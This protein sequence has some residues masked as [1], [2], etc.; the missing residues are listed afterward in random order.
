MEELSHVSLSLSHICL[1]ANFKSL[2]CIQIPRHKLNSML[3]VTS[4]SQSKSIFVHE[5]CSETHEF[6]TRGFK[7]STFL[8]FILKRKYWLSFLWNLHRIFLH[9]QKNAEYYNFERTGWFPIFKIWHR[10]DRKFAK[11][12]TMIEDFP[13]SPMISFCWLTSYPIETELE[14]LLKCKVHISLS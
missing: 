1:H 7:M 5:P 6:V 2:E 4:Q 12:Q 14:S 11:L 10:C 8:Y 13:I 9:R 3:K